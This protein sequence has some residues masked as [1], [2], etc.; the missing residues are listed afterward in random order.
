MY[1]LPALLVVTW[2]GHGGKDAPE[3]VLMGEISPRLLELLGIPHRVLTAD[4][5]EADLAWA[6]T[7]MDRALQP[8][9]LLVPPKV[10]EIGKAHA[11]STSEPARTVAGP[12]RESTLPRTLAPSL[13]RLDAVAAARRPRGLR[14]RG[15]RLH[16]QPADDLRRGP[17]RPARRLGRLSIRLRGGECRRRHRGRQRRAGHRWPALHPGEG[18]ARASRGPAHP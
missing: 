7:V 6:V 17:S 5:L 16:G 11:H 14:Q 8:V 3:H 4:S 18:H 9:A 13:S 2:R 12:R 1:G 15:L 10:V